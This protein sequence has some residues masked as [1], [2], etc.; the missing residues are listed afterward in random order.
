MYIKGG[1]ISSKMVWYH[2]PLTYLYISSW[3]LYSP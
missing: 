2:F 1:H 3:Q